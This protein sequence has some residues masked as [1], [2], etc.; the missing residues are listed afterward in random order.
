MSKQIEF[1]EDAEPKVSKKG[2]FRSFIDGTILAN[3]LIIKQLPFILFLTFL[4]M[5]YIGNRYH[6]EKIV[7]EITRLKKEIQ[8]LRAESISTSAELMYKSTKTQVLKA[9]KEKNLGLEESMVPP[10]KIV[11]E[12]RGK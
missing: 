1:I 11:I 4:A 5:I 7:R 6:A 3:Q 9:I 2:I 10:G 8:E 12:K